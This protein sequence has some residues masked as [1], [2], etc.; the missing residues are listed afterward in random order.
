MK[1]SLHDT[2]VSCVKVASSVLIDD[3]RVYIPNVPNIDLAVE[4][5]MASLPPMDDQ[6]VLDVLMV[7]ESPYKPSARCF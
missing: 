1:L 2:K 4:Q 7:D 5:F 3:S 6:N